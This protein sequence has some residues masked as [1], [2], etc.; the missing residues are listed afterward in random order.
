M[1]K[2]LHYKTGRKRQIFM[3]GYS[4]C[5]KNFKKKCNFNDHV[6]VH[7]RSRP[8]KCK[9]C[10]K[11]HV[12]KG[13]CQRHQKKCFDYLLNINW[14][15]FKGSLCWQVITCHLRCILLASL[16]RLK[17]DDE[18]SIAS[19]QLTAIRSVAIT[20]CIV[21]L[22]VSNFCVLSFFYRKC[23]YIILI[24]WILFVSCLLQ[25]FFSLFFSLE[26]HCVFFGKRAEKICWQ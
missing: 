21:F 5:N 22:W 14:S 3:C 13:N 10:H 17:F 25:N 8:F 15:S 1:V 4:N 19:V 26:A 9:Y 12:Q 20:I 6:M 2:I 7:Q 24:S 16:V 23:H 18:I 11:G